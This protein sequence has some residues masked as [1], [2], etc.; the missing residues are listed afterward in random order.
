[1]RQVLHML[2]FNFASALYGMYY[3]TLLTIVLVKT[4]KY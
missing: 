3:F 1:M 2:Y 4:Q